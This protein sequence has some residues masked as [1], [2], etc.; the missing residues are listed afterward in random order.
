L[1]DQALQLEVRSTPKLGRPAISPEETTLQLIYHAFNARD[2]DALEALL[3]ED[4]HWPKGWE[5][6]H[7]EGRK[8]VRQYW[9]R[10]WNWI[11][12]SMTPTR[13]RPLADG[14]IEVTV[15][16]VVWDLGGS[17]LSNAPV[18]HTYSFRD[19]LVAAMVIGEPDGVRG[20]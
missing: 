1:R 7:L 18:T 16:Q 8:A 15:H 12:P 19:G 9:L 10:Q 14:S 20:G 3:T 4:V 13:F 2:M 17:L 5:S 6:G 11:E